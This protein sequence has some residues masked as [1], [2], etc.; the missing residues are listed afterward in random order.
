MPLNSLS[1]LLQDNMTNYDQEVD[2]IRIY[3]QPILEEFESWLK[4]TGVTPKTVK[5]HMDNIGFFGEYLIYSEP[6]NKLDEADANDVYSFLADWFPRKAMWAS[7][8]STK[9]NMAS[10][11]K[12]FKF[13]RESNRVYDDTEIEVRDTL[14]EN[15]DE[16]LA[17]L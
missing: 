15:K 8:S 4:S 7:E 13:L 6:L 3:N 5:N 14:K 9:S 16:F 12:F 1:K 10:F 17:G 2:K 11:R